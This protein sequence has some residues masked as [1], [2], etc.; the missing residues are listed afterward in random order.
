MTL[1]L[2]LEI[3]DQCDIKHIMNRISGVMVS[4]L[5]SSAVDCG[6]KPRLGQTKY[7]KISFGCFSAKLPVLR[8]NSKYWFAGNR[9]NVSEW[10]DMSIHR[11]LFHYKKSNSSS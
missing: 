5:A 9:D 11:L 4:V 1:I 3:I 6:F 2:A 7:Y 10:I 8:S